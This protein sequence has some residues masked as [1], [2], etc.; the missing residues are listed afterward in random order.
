MNDILCQSWWMPALRGAVAIAFGLIALFW[1]GLTLLGL[2]GLFA[3]YALLGGAI[4][5]VAAMRYRKTHD[6]WWMPLLLGI[7]ALGAGVIAVIHP[8]LS[9]MVLVMLIGAHAMISGILDIAM[10]IRLRKVLHHE[11]L[12]ALAGAAAILFGV[13]A[14]LFPG[15][16]A[17]AIVWMISVYALATGMLLVALAFRLRATAPGQRKMTQERRVRPDRRMV[18]AH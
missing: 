18:H 7:V 15:A 6:D 9:V 5:V 10:A 14:F 12:L 13:L 4:S 1:P 8:A 3:A 11:W 2:V 17:L 16:G